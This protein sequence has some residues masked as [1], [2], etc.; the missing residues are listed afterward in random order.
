MRDPTLPTAR[1]AGC[2]YALIIACGLWSE[3]VARAGLDVWDVARGVGAE[4]VGQLG[5]EVV[6]LHRGVG[7]AEEED[8]LRVRA[9]E[10]GGGPGKGL[11]PAPTLEGAVRAD[12][13]AVGAVVVELVV[14]EPILVRQPDDLEPE[15]VLDLHGAGRLQALRVADEEPVGSVGQDYEG[16]EAE[17]DAA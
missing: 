17:S 3:L 15:L 6:V 10:E 8:A 2:L 13:R 4:R 5:E 1:A 14:D 9:A 16:Y 11:F 7:G 12:V